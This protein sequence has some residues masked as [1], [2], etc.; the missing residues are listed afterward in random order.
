MGVRDRGRTDVAAFALAQNGAA[1]CDIV[2]TNAHVVT[3]DDE[4]S[5]HSPGAVAV[6]GREILAVGPTDQVSAE[7]SAVRVI[8]ARGALVHPGL[9]EP[10]CHVTVHTSR[11]ALPDH[12]PDPLATSARAGFGAFSRWFNALEADDEHA[13]AM[14]ACLEMALAGVT[15]FMDPGTAFEPDAVADA[16][17]RIGIRGSVADPFLWDVEGNLTLASEIDRAPASSER[18]LRLLGEEAARRNADPDALVRGHVAVYGSGSASDALERAA[19]ECADTHGCVLTQHQ[20]LDAADAANDR[21]RYGRDALVHLAAIGALGPN[22]SFMHMNAL[23]ADEL[24]AVADSGM[25]VIWHPGNVLFYGIGGPGS[26]HML[27]LRGRGV[28]LAVGTDVAKAWS[29]GEMGWLAYLLARA[30][31]GFLSSEDV[32]TIQTRAGA[33]AVGRDADLGSIEPGKRADLVVRRSD[34]PEAHPAADPLRQAV[35]VARGKSVDTVVV[36]GRIVVEGGRSVN[37]DA[38]AVYEAASA[39]ARR[40]RARAEAG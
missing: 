35:L 4:R 33:R 19:K 17:Q 34:L 10:H 18:A 14:L 23:S 26:P 36:D 31:G 39:S 15:S 12:P 8:D 13:S 9:V 37:V 25:S 5:V 24:D 16:A 2:I 29:F 28:P 1:T 3:M 32:L 6:R 38:A 20:S 27:D 7:H 30:G 40:V 21:A 22:C 11:G